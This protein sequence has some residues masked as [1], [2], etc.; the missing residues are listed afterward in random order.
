MYVCMYVCCHQSQP[1]LPCPALPQKYYTCPHPVHT[2]LSHLTYLS[3]PCTYVFVTLDVPVPTVYIRICHTWRTC[4][5]PVAV[6]RIQIRSRLGEQAQ[7]RTLPTPQRALSPSFPK[8]RVRFSSYTCTDLKTNFNDKGSTQGVGHSR[9]WWSPE[10][11]T[12]GA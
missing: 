10:A 11:E 5:A 9:T 12:R 8:F 4:P 1:V 6:Y 2:Y 7:P 3:P